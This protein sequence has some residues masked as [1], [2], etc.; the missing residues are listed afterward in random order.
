MDAETDEDMISMFEEDV[1]G[2]ILKNAQ[3]LPRR[4]WCSLQIAAD[5]DTSFELEATLNVEI[6]CKDP[7]GRTKPYSIRIATLTV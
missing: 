1:D 4:N 6:N 7:Q 5:K 3:L 2:Q